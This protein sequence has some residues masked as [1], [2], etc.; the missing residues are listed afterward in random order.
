MRERCS[1]ALVPGT[2]RTDAAIADY[3]L[4][5][6]NALAK[7]DEGA[8]GDAHV[9]R[10]ISFYRRK[11]FARA[12]FTNAG[13]DR[14]SLRADAVAGSVSQVPRAIAPSAEISGGGDARGLAVLPRGKPAP[15]GV[16]RGHVDGAAGR[17]SPFRYAKVQCHAPGVVKSS[18]W[19]SRQGHRTKFTPSGVAN[20]VPD[21]D[22]PPLEDSR[23]ANGKR[24]PT[25]TTS[26]CGGQKRRELPE[27]KRVLVEGR[28]GPRWEDQQSGQ[29]S[30]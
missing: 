12:E 18:C 6:R 17:P 3:G 26:C 4:A 7:A 13:R 16:L 29:K 23:A 24:S 20:V 9:Y 11:D 28:L 8:S 19:A 25:G 1:C 5:A 10:G 2:R 14:P 27:G 22:Q 21:R 30:I 15:D